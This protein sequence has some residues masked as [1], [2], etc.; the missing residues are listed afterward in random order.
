[1]RRALVGAGIG[2]V[3][4]VL[5]LAVLG[6]WG[7][8]THGEEWVAAP[9]PPPAEAAVIWALRAVAYFWWLAG[10]VGGVFGGLAGLA[11]WL[12]R[13]KPPSEPS[14]EEHLSRR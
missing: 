8:Y 12:V 14:V 10:G 6:A 4:G 7:G 11:S 1:M 3:C 13:P 9:A 2:A 5:A